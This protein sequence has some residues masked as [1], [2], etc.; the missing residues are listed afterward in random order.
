MVY[1]L[2]FDPANQLEVWHS[3]DDTPPPSPHS[4][5]VPSVIPSRRIYS[6]K[7]EKESDRGSLFSTVSR[8]S[9]LKLLERSRP[10]VWGTVAGDNRVSWIEYGAGVNT[11]RALRDRTPVVG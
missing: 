1:P 8:E 9:S 10:C 3:S 4:R 5:A 2:H 7:T 11:C 6:T